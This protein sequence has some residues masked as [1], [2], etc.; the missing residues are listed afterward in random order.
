[1]QRNLQIIVIKALV[2]YLMDT[3]P[4]DFLDLQN[5]AFGFRLRDTRWE[6]EQKK[7]PPV[8]QKCLDLDIPNPY[9]QS[10]PS[11]PEA[12]NPKSAGPRAEWTPPCQSANHKG[13]ASSTVSSPWGH[14]AS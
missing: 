2:L 1:M 12:L 10:Q 7:S 13:L 8:L 9:S 14:P 5:T 3:E 11:N 4:A 6:Q